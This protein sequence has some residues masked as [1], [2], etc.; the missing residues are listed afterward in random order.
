MS[1]LKNLKLGPKLIL[2]GMLIMIVPL[3]VVGVISVS[4]AA[5]G[6]SAVEEEQ[7]G[8]R[9]RE[10]SG[11]IDNVLRVETKI[12]HSLALSPLAVEASAA[13]SGSQPAS[14]DPVGALSRYFTSI[15]GTSGIGDEYQVVLAFSPDGRAYAASDPKYLGVSVADRPYFQ[16]ALAGRVNVG[17]ANLNKVTKV[18]FV[19]I[20]APITGADGKV[21]GVVAVILDL[22]FMSKL[23]GDARIGAS[24]YAYLIDNEGLFIAHPVAENVFTLNGL[25]QKGME[26]FT[27]EMISGKSGV[28]H[29]VFKGVAK[30]AGFAPV[31]RAG[32]SVALTI[33]NGEF[34]QAAASVRTIVLIVGAASALAAAFLFVLFARSISGPLARAVEFSRRIAEG[35]LSARIDIRRGDEVG[36]LADAL[37]GMAEKLLGI[38]AQVR[39]ASDNV[40][41]GS[42]QLSLGAQS[43]S[44]GATEQAAA[45][46]EVSSSME[47]M[48]AN[49]KQNT[50]NAAQ[51][52]RISSKAAEAAR[53]GGASVAETV[54]AMKE[55]AGKITIIEEI[56]RQTNLLA[57]NAAIEAARAGEHGKGFAVVASEVRKLAERS[58]KAAAEIGQLSSSSV[59]VAEKA[60]GLLARI[61]PDIQKTADLVQ[62]ISAASMEQNSGADQINKALMQLDEVIQQNAARAEDL[63][64]TAEELAGQ[65]EQ[66]QTIMGFFQVEATGARTVSVAAASPPANVG[67]SRGGGADGDDFEQY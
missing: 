36:I 54:R 61:V 57:L 41:Q 22:G 33:P 30:T 43:M 35:E 56:A 55:I 60:G 47:Q 59:Q 31:P 6:L 23:I 58:Q 27:K 50:D 64:S 7:L 18:P 10:I 51:T 2:A 4:R 21:A 9:A 8:T 65:A 38:V 17:Q 52:E 45:G 66:L 1:M 34:L 37:R 3:V 26:D 16:D 62:E 40:A 20:A 32:W 14:G 19:P 48:G 13:S 67:L 28:G 15:K 46:E 53:E 5:R 29:Y 25:T 42:Q 12:V 63:S 44:Q 49:I 11:M 39:G 24:G